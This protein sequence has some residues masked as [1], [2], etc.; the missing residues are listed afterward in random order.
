MMLMGSCITDTG[1]AISGNPHPR[2]ATRRL[3]L[4]LCLLMFLASGALAQSVW[5]EKFTGLPAGQL[6]EG[7]RYAINVYGEDI[8]I[9]FQYDYGG[10]VDMQISINGGP[11]NSGFSCYWNDSGNQPAYCFAT[12]P[13]NCGKVTFRVHQLRIVYPYDV[14]SEPIDIYAFNGP[15]CLPQCDSCSLAASGQGT[16]QPINVATGK[17]WYQKTDLALSGPDGL[18]FSRW[19]DNQSGYSQ[20]LGFGWRHNYSAYL[21]LSFL[22]QNLV[23]FHD[24]EDRIT[25]FTKIDPHFPQYDSVSGSTLQESGSAY[26]LTT[27]DNAGYVFDSAGRLT[28]LVDRIGNVQT[29]ARDAGNGYRI[30]S[31]TDSLGRSLNFS[32]DASNRI[33]AIATTPAGLSESFTYDGGPNCGTGNLCSA[34]LPDGKTWTYEYTDANPHNLTKALDPLGHAEENNTYSGNKCVAQSTEGGQNTLNLSYG[35]GTTTVTD[36]LA[37]QTTYTYNPNLLL[38][39]NVSGPGCGCGGGQSRSFTWDNFLRKTS[40]TNGDGKTTTWTYGRDKTLFHSYDNFT[41]LLSAYPSPTSRSEPLSMGV[42]RETDWTYYPIYDPPASPDPIQDLV[43]TE[44]VPSADTP[45]QNKVTTNTFNLQGLLT[46]RAEQGYV[47]GVSTTYTSNFTYD[48]KGRILTAEDPRTDITTYGYYP[49]NDSDLAR[50]G[51]L[52]SVTD[53]VGNATTYATAPPPNNTYDLYGHALSVT[54]ANGVVRDMT[55]DLRGRLLTST[56][57]GVPGDPA[58][59]TN[60]YTY[61]A[62]GRLTYSLLPANNGSNYFYDGSNRL[63]TIKPFAASTIFESYNYAYDVMGQKTQEKA[64]AGASASPKYLE[65]F[66]YDN[67]GRLS[68]IDHPVPSGAK[69]V[70]GYDGAGNLTSV[71]DEN[72]TSPNTLYAYDFANRLLSVTQ[73]QVNM[74]GPDI[75]TSYTY[76]IQDNLNQVTDPNGNVTTYSYDDFRRLHTQVSPVS[77]TTT[78]AYDPA[79]NLV[80]ST[81]ANGA[82]T[83]RIYDAD[84]RV[85]QAQSVRSGFATETV[86]WTYDDA[87]SGNFGKG[88]LAS[89]TDPSGSAAYAYERRGMLKNEIKT[90]AS[91]PF[92]TSYTYDANGNRKT[93]TYPSG[94]VVTYA[95]DYANRPTQATSGA[96][97][98]VSSA[99]YQPF[100]PESIVA[101]GNGTTRTLSYD[102]R[103]R[104]TGN[105]LVKGATTIANFGYQDDAL[106]NITQIH[107]ATDATYNRDFGY[108]DLNRVKTANS[109]SSLWGAGSYSYD[110]MGNTL[111]LALGSARTAT[112]SYSGTL[113]KLTQVMETGFGTRPVSYDAVGNE[114]LVGTGNFAYSSRNNLATGDGLTYTYDGRGVRT[115]VQDDL[116]NKRYF[117]YTPEL[118]LLAETTL[119]PNPSTTGGYEYVWFN[120]H[121][122]AEENGGTHWTFTDHLG[123]P[124]L[125]TDSTGTGSFW[126]VEYEPYGRVFT[127]RTSDQ[128]QPLR[129]LGQEAEQL[130][131]LPNG[132][133]ERDYNIFRWY[134]YGWGRYTQADPLGFV[135]PARGPSSFQHHDMMTSRFYIP[136]LAVTDVMPTDQQNPYSYV[137]ENPLNF[138]DPSGLLGI[139]PIDVGPGDLF[140]HVFAHYAEKCF[141]KAKDCKD[142][143]EGKCYD[144]DSPG[145]QGSNVADPIWIECVQK[146]PFCSLLL[147]YA[148]ACAWLQPFPIPDIPKIPE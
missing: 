17:L 27:W 88:R 14:Y 58:D 29:I 86:N 129:F 19:Y 50:R 72:H 89:M 92:T 4:G 144:P 49:D 30:S 1:A 59:L 6:P 5:I 28:A 69:I 47:G 35:S 106:G 134:R 57:K 44:T 21:D 80:T 105:Q 128:H 65:S 142:K 74:P 96:T 41:E 91:T 11:Y 75:V 104:V 13:Y 55:Y 70:Y 132:R 67:Y 43:L 2:P 66:Q 138:M 130:N 61:D 15:A 139:G 40:E 98:Y 133:T 90:I 127:L 42:N 45:G 24:Q 73:R 20:D 9:T 31:V 119:A 143:V 81:D 83:T 26:L 131:F 82:T 60:H 108:D 146:N 141:D 112:F 97:T 64:L 85:T 18:R 110:K 102:I 76:D 122:V 56:V 54:D 52:L 36:G 135:R 48:S 147:K 23:T 10:T 111:S 121:P 107:D 32:Y 63:K 93:L 8:Q 62:A 25:Y 33:N 71:Q 77:G 95:Y 79:G 103:Y 117:F 113:P 118:S 78:Y 140:C 109:G 51:Q 38:V 145:Y 101:Y 100:G 94:R 99:I 7:Y 136:Q 53:A 12:L 120:G 148:V 124:L 39:T 87:T 137:Q 126:R 46:A 34:T 16:G 116:G 22:S 114:T 84:N 37:R 123:T 115:V 68:E 3:L 125:L